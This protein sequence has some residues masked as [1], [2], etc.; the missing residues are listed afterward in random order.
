MEEQKNAEKI[1][2]SLQ[3]KRDDNSQ[4]VYEITPPLEAAKTA[5]FAAEMIRVFPNCINRYGF[6]VKLSKRADGSNESFV[7]LGI[8]KSVSESEHMQVVEWVKSK[9]EAL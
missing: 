7:D 1:T 4:W 8:E 6:A 9:I 5:G 3:E 2:Y